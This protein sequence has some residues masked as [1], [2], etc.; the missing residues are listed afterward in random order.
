MSSSSKLERAREIDGLIDEWLRD[1]GVETAKPKDVMPFLIQRGAFARD[2]RQGL[3]LRKLLRE[4]HRSGNLSVMKTVQF[5][6]KAKNNLWYFRL[7]S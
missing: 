1:T 7:P 6:Q 3:P 4:L 5:E 2:H